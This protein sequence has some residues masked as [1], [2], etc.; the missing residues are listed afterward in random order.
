MA[1]LYC[2]F[3]NNKS[4]ISSLIT[5]NT[6]FEDKIIGKTLVDDE[7]EFDNDDE[8]DRESSS[9]YDDKINTHKL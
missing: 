4:S 5:T 7:Y 8:T 6:A 9:Q 1:I 3:Y 2:L